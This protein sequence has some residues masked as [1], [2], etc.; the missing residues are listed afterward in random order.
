[1]GKDLR[2]WKDAEKPKEQWEGEEQ[3]ARDWFDRIKDFC[4]ERIDG[5]GDILE[6]VAYSD[7]VVTAA[8]IDR[9]TPTFN[10]RTVGKQLHITLRETTKGR[11]RQTVNKCDRENGFEAWRLLHLT[12]KP[13][14]LGDEN[15]LHAE[16]LGMGNTQCK[17]PEQVRLRIIDLEEKCRRYTDYSGKEVDQASLKSCLTN[18]LDDDTT[19]NDSWLPG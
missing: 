18:M 17:D 7:D 15:A 19:K 4:D 14:V 9:L 13:K 1:M 16:I 3:T 2:G 10:V 12:F 5:L 8:D 11:A 6:S